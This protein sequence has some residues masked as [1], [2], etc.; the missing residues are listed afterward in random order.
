MPA[1]V[2]TLLQELV[3]IPSVNPDNAPGTDQ[4]GEAKVAE[5][6][7][8]WL[9]GIGAEVTLEE[10]FPGRPN[11][12]ARFAPRDGRR[13]I[14]FGPHLDTVGINGMTID[15]FAAEI[16]DGRVWGRGT[17]DTKGPMAAMLWALYECRE[18]LANAPITIDFVAFM[19]EESG[20]WGSKEFGK[21]YAAEY[22]FALVGEPTSMQVVHATKGSLWAT[23]RATGKAAHSSQPERGENAILK[24]SRSLDLLDRELSEKLATFTH[25]LLGRSTM[26]VG[27]IRG[28]SR[29]NVVPDEAEAEIDIRITPSLAQS[30]GALKVLTETIQ[31]LALPLEIVNPH[32]NIP[33]ETSPDHPMIQA[34]TA[35]DP[36][37]GLTGAPWFSDAGHLSKAGIPS[38]CIGP[39]SIDQA[40]TEDEFID[41][42]ALQ[43]GTALFTRFIR[44]LL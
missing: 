20:Q 12:I 18:Q 7:S 2:V 1:D 19:A 39:G 40:H 17:S 37:I 5:F 9:K 11:L 21:K 15:P 36:V 29:P 23:L 3:R 22:D 16:R 14:L 13:R 41:I 27:V 4:T 25:P 6:L 43:Q 30:G 44:G 28:G 35:T 10:V 26:N 31:G 24:L 38:I 34:L 8:G 33:M 32:E 42:T